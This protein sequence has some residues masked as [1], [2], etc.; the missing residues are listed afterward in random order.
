MSELVAIVTHTVHAGQMAAAAE[1]IHGNGL[2]MATR[3]GFLDR[4]LLA[5][6]DGAERLVTVTRWQS[7]AT[8]DDWV[9]HNR[10]HNPHAGTTA[11]FDPPNTLLLID[12]S[13]AVTA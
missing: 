4:R 8:Y 12:V 3:P 10:D 1:R 9:S 2:R 13:V 7:Q 5:P 6:T 11:P